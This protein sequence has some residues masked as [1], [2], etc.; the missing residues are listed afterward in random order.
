MVEA[1]RGSRSSVAWRSRT[2]RRGVDLEVAQD[3]VQV[4]VRQVDDLK[5]PV[6]ELDVRDCRA[7]CRR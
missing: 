1:P 6:R 7:A 3:A 5:E 2:S 4:R